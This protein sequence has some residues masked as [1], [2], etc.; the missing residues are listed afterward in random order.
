M[1]LGLILMVL[2]VAGAGWLLGWMIL[3]FFKELGK[4]L[5]TLAG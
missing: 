5:R 3:D 2:G 1:A 4:M